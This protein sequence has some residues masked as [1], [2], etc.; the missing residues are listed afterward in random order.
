MKRIMIAAA[1]ALLTT[2]AW[3]QSKQDTQAACVLG[4]AALSIEQGAKTVDE[5]R[6]AGWRH[7]RDIKQAPP[8]TEDDKEIAGD[9]EEYLNSVIYRMFRTKQ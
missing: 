6:K 1:F 3:A 7:C 2:T 4:W 8:R 5:A 9:R